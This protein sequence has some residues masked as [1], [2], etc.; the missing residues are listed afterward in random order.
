MA[1][2][3][4]RL[5]SLPSLFDAWKRIKAKGS[6]GGL[7]GVTIYDF[8]QKLDRHIDRLRRDLLSRKYVPAPLQRINISK[9]DGSGEKRP[10]SLPSVRD[11]IAQ[12]AMRSIIEP[13][14]NAVFLDCSY[15]YRPGKGPGKVLKRI[16]HH[17]HTEGKHW[18]VIADFDRFFDSLDQDVLQRQ[19]AR[20][21]NDPDMLRLIRMWVKIGSVDDRGRYLDM[22]AGVGQGS[23]IS[24]LLANIYAHPLDEYMVQK[25][26]AY[27]RYSDNVIAFC[28]TAGQAEKAWDDMQSF[29]S[30]VLML[31]FNDNARPIR[32]LEHGFVFLGIYYKAGQWAISTGKMAQI[33]RRIKALARPGAQPGPLIEKMNRS[34]A[35]IRRYYGLI[36]PEPQLV[37]LDHYMASRLQPVLTVYLKDKRFKN[38]G[39][40]L[41]YLEGIELLSRTCICNR[42]KFLRNLAG[43]ALN[44][45]LKEPGRLKG[46]KCVGRAADRGIKSAE[47]A[48]SG[49][50]RKFIR[51]QGV[52]SEV[53]ISTHGTFAGKTG[54]RLVVKKQRKVVLRSRLD[55]L[56]SVIIAARGVTLSSD[57][58]HECSTRKI[59]IFFLGMRGPPYAMINTPVH[60]HAELGRSQLEAEK[61]GL[62]VRLAGW[63]VTGKIKNQLNLM[64][65]YGR[66]RK[67]EPDFIN[68]LQS[69]K[70]EISVWI[71]DVRQV[72]RKSNQEVAQGR[73][74]SIEGRAASSYWNMAKKLFS[75]RVDFPGRERR[76][77]RDLVNSLLNYGYGILYAKV[78]RAV[79]LAGLN[80][81]L[82]FLHSPRDG[83]PALVFDL[84]EEFRCQVV[85]RAVFTML[86]RGESLQLEQKTGLLSKA[87]RKKLIENVLE[88]M[89][90]LVP[91]RGKKVTLDQVVQN[92]PKALAEALLGEKKYRPFVGRY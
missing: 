30:Q 85:D 54:A 58:I 49:Q 25:G 35:G 81:Q 60:P 87:T 59:P 89:A 92:Q 39:E 10:L 86:T 40:L 9:F 26:H 91:Y 78:W 62:A 8:E 34:L 14:F 21:I 5:C 42:N 38:M 41:S 18:V 7:D 33:K 20:R 57:L 65:F 77:A 2:I 79:V 4:D 80:P 51:Q 88:R 29:S 68:G 84:I 19:V 13:I 82:S 66:S 75:D 83:K 76:G 43:R 56:Q 69:F 28:L 32:K 48:V 1:A 63:I 17:L 70:K 3:F 37:E 45:S 15:A 44:V 16:R 61:N 24:P 27:I 53:V 67:D 90:T 31:K 72:L 52:A 12:Q 73:L 6:A 64:K 22:H 50:K 47:R 55:R 23:V 71:R 36:D 46:G 74:F 11:K